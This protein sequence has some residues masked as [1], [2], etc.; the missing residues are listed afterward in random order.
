MRKTPSGGISRRTFV[1]ALATSAATITIV[2]RHVLGGQAFTA[3]SDTLNIAAVG[4]GGRGRSDLA[5]C[6]HE[7]IVALCDVD[8][9]SAENS[10]RRFPQARRYKDFRVML[11]KETD[12]DA[13][14]VATPDHTHAVI[15]MAAMQRGKHVY[16]EKPLTRTIG[17]AR[18]LAKAA[19]ATGVATQMGNQGHAGE[20]TRQIREWIEAGRIGK[21]S[22]VHYWTNRPIWPQAINRPTETYH[23]PQYLDWDL[24]LGPAPF[25][26]YHPAYHPFRWRGWWDYGTGALGDIACHAMDA[27]FWTFDLRDPTRITA[28]STALFEETAPTSSRIEYDFPAKAG[29]PALKVV[30]R[31]GGVNPGRP[32]Q[33]EEDEALPSPSGQLF[34]G[35]QGLLAAG[36]Y[37]ENPRLYPK[38]L[39]AAVIAEPPAPTYPRTAGV[40]QEWIDACKGKGVPGSN[41]ADYSAPLTE[42]V[43]LGN[44]ALRTAET[45][46]WNAEEGRVTNVEKANRYLQA[47]YRPG[48]GDTP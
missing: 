37:G 39:H 25:R 19:R 33:L 6:A 12:V 48:W 47:E 18:A 45:L 34:V 16:C 43:L 14:I 1:G 17:E 31:D 4:V 7:N 30:W 28:E 10:F 41:F 42:M 2:P 5:G 35:E 24:F 27:A 32:P 40:Y 15:A 46:E 8:W 20:G 23:V 3:P 26:P 11:E 29:R 22:E 38:K 21:V 9:Q 13:V 36:I 44:L